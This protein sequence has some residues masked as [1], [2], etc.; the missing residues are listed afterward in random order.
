MSIWKIA[1]RS[2]QQRALS[3][4]LTALSMALGV[5][6]IVA[7]LVIHGVVSQSFNRNAAG[8][9][10][11]VTT[12][13]GKL[14]AV[15]NTVFHLGTAGEPLPYTYYEEFINTPEKPGQFAKYVSFAIPYCLGDSYEGFRVIGTTPEMFDKF[16][17]MQGRRYEFSEG[18]NFAQTDFFGGVIGSLVARRTGLKVGSEFQPT[19]G[20]TEGEDPHKHDP[21]IVRG[22]LAPT[23]TPNDR[24][25]F[26]NM[27]GFYL[28]EGHAKDPP[29]T[30]SAAADAHDHADGEAHEEATS[31]S[32]AGHAHDAVAD[33]H[34]AEPSAE[35][36]H[37]D[38]DHEAHDH[39]AHDH[40]HAHAHT[41]LPKSQREVTAVLIRTSNLMAGMT[42]PR[43]INEGPVAQAVQP[44]REIAVLFSG[45]VGNLEM[46]LLALSV[47]VIL[48]AGIGIMVSMYNSMSDRRREIGILRALGAPRSTI[49]RVI[50]VESLL[51]AVGGGVAGF[52]LGHGLIGAMGPWITD[53][54]GVQIG[55]FAMAAPFDIA[56]HLG[57]IGEGHKWPIPTELVLI[58]GLAILAQL[59][60]ILPAVA[61]YR[62][63]VSRA[64]A[65]SP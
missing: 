58:G 27:E 8:Y 11:I 63:D 4:I 35:A 10:M 9:D 7:V 59:V 33:G 3:S 19:H 12:K 54:T 34:T 55:W 32:E 36:A 41:P 16:E 46:L 37:D 23:G 62:T 1:W 42:L 52:L 44:Q 56:Q 14:E 43:L 48:V 13:G 15:L 40:G 47:L 51:L 29:A 28:L 21:F 26:V 65:N 61:A 50:L 24:A 5:A 18:K 45:L 53:Q 64:L 30:E 31:L 39:A 49:V 60:G 2:I 25:V 57:S 6:L 38:H 20:V 22:V 17:Y